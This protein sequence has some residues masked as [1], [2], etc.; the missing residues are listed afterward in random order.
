MEVQRVGRKESFLCEP[1]EAEGGEIE[2]RG[3]IVEEVG[4][5]F[6]D[7]RGEFEAVAG[8]GAR[9]EDRG[10][11][12]MVV[13]DEV[14]VGSIGVN[15]N[16]GG[17]KRSAGGGQKTAEQVADGFGFG[18]A[19]V[20]ANGI[21]MGVFALMM[22]G[23]FDAVAQ[24]GKAVEKAV[25]FIF[26]DVDGAVLREEVF[27]MGLGREPEEDLAFDG[28]REET[29]HPLLRKACGGQ[30]GPLPIRWGE[31]DTSVVPHPRMMI[32]IKRKRR[33]KRKQ[34]ICPGAG[35][36]EE[37]AGDIGAGGGVD[38]DSIAARFPSDH[39]LVEAKSGAVFGGDFEMGLD[40]ELRKETSSAGFPDG[41]H[42][43]GWL[44]DW[45]AASQF[46]GGKDLVGEFVLL[47]AALRADEEDAVGR[48]DHQAA[49]LLEELSAGGFFQVGPQLIGA[50]DERHVE[51]VLEIGLA[52][53]AGQAV[54]GTEIVRRFE[55]IKTQDALPARGEVI[56][57]GAAHRAE[58][59]DDNIVGVQ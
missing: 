4:G 32:T 38:G 58:A 22:D 27:V 39:R 20:A 8:T 2:G 47:G 34:G 15:A 21:G 28:E 36:E 59:G 44:E 35:G 23:D 19:N 29:P 3:L 5:E 14:F 12:G 17:F 37:A 6:A 1:G 33:R 9:D 49:G 41:D 11:G 46:G 26:P 51:R 24:V 45:K 55:A 10:M 42:V 7:D 52:D 57:R 53:D 31:E 13:E 56:G 40:G 54:R 25:W 50:L 16:N 43:V 18:G 48:A 30:A